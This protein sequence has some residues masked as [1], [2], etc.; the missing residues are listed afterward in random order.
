MPAGGQQHPVDDLGDLGGAG[1][2]AVVQLLVDDEGGSGLGR[3]LV[4][5]PGRRALIVTGRFSAV[6]IRRG[7]VPAATR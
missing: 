6:V 3:R 5:A 7:V 1:R 4:T 2:G